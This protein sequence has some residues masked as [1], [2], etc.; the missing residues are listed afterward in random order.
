MGGVGIMEHFKVITSKEM[1]YKTQL[2]INT[3]DQFKHDLTY[4]RGCL[5]I[6]VTEYEATRHISLKSVEHVQS[7]LEDMESMLNDFDARLAENER[8]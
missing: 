7:V 1:D 2:F 4:L 6:F 3:V 8:N 5:S